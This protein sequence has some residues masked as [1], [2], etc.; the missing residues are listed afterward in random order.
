MKYIDEMIE[1]VEDEIEGAMEYA[2]EYIVHRAAG[3]MTRASQYREMA[4]QEHNHATI[5]RD[6]AIQDVEDIKR[7]H[8]LSEEEDQHWHHCMR[9]ITEKLAMVKTLLA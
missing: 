1:K 4:L 7:V 6:Y 8:Q 5:L 3:N 2:E 9:R